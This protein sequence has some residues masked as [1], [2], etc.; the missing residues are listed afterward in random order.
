MFC[1]AKIRRFLAP[2]GAAPGGTTALAALVTAL[3]TLCG[4][5]M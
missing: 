4:C 2:I 3:V 1:L 5:A